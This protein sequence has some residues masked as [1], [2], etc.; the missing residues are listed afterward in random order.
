M[1]L[2]GTIPMIPLRDLL[3][4][5]A[6]SDKTGCLQVVHEKRATNLFFQSGR[7]V[8]C[9]ADDPAKLLG[10]YLLYRGLI[11]EDILRS[12]MAQQETTGESLRTIF[13]AT[14]R[15][16][17]EELGRVVIEK[18]EETL[19][20]LFD[21]DEATFSFRENMLPRLKDTVISFDVADIVIRGVRRGEEWRRIRARLG[22]PG[23]ILRHTGRDAP[24]SVLDD[25]PTRQVYHAVDGVR[26]IAEIVL[27]VHGIEFLVCRCL[28]DLLED[29]LVARAGSR[30]TEGTRIFSFPGSPDASRRSTGE[31]A[32]VCDRPEFAEGGDDLERARVLLAGG[33]PEA[34]IEILG[35]AHRAD[36]SDSAVRRLMD[37]A[38]RMLVEQITRAGFAPEKVPVAVGQKVDPVSGSLSPAD[39]FL[40]HL[41]DGTWSVRALMWV[42][43][44][45]AVEVLATLRS[46]VDRGYVEFRE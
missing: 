26:T 7:V 35:D 39:D 41:S 32:T 5:L 17:S 16:T 27:H 40:L 31:R 6:A 18:A 4:L 36:P 14:R 9:S 2:F 10:Q 21:L 1:S 37:E 13:V 11:T 8:A 12:A 38:E 23:T 44:M 30:E 28:F 24:G 19:H 33:D 43:P 34:A 45:R 20:A 22:G 29:G 15:I 25:W 42:S 3:Q 46:L